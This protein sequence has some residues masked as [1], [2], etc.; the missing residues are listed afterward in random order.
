MHERKFNHA[1]SHCGKDSSFSIISSQF[2]SG[3]TKD[4]QYAMLMCD[5][6]N[7]IMFFI[8]ERKDEEIRGVHGKGR[9]RPSSLVSD[10]LPR[11]TTENQKFL[12]QVHG[13]DIADFYPR[14]PYRLHEAIPQ[15]IAQDYAEAMKCFDSSCFKATVAMCRRTM[16][17]ICKDKGADRKLMLDKQIEA[18][19]PSDLADYS[20]EIRHWGNIGSHPDEDIT[21]VKPEEART[22]LE[23]IDL[24][25]DRLYINPH[26]LRQSKEKR[27]K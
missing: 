25:F 16:Q 8:F 2:V 26:K 24:V 13:F 17:S 4:R 5:S 19:V 12:I 21:E 1:C 11:D 3:E 7:Q 22:M 14:R 18:V 9:I 20:H 23:F 27:G 6:C 10:P 15:Y